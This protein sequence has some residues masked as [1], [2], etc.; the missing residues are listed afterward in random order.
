V[1]IQANRIH[2]VWCDF[3]G[4]FWD[5]VLKARYQSAHNQ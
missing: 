1:L 5:G 2:S 3:N 4:D